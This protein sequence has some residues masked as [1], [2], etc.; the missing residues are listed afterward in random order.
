M[1][2]ID[3]PRNSVI[4]RR[5]SF[6]ARV[7]Y[8]HLSLRTLKRQFGTV[9]T[10]YRAWRFKGIGSSERVSRK[11]REVTFVYFSQNPRNGFLMESDAIEEIMKLRGFRPARYEE[12]I[13]FARNYPDE[14]DKYSIVAVGSVIRN[15]Y[16]TLGVPVLSNVKG[17]TRLNLRWEKGPWPKKWRF[18]A[19]PMQNVRKAA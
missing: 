5:G 11:T 4:R 2:K 18:L 6:T 19:V 13:G 7:V 9:N 8:R 3:Y 1:E 10:E 16:G 12:L 15:E 14:L 17:G